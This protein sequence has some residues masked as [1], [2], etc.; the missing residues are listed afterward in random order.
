MS[1]KTAFGVMQRSFCDPLKGFAPGDKPSGS[2]K[3]AATGTKAALLSAIR[4][5][6][7]DNLNLAVAN[8]CP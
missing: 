4:D 3:M 1:Q 2:Q 8:N 5:Y 7:R 6:R